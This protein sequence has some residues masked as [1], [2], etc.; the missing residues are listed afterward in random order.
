MRLMFLGALLCALTLFA[1]AHVRAQAQADL[2]RVAGIPVDATA[3]SAVAAREQALLAGQREGLRRLLARLTLPEDA[4]RLPSLDGLSIEP[5]VESFQIADERLSPTRYLATLSV[6]YVP[7]QVRALL[8]DSGTPHLDRR[9]EPVLVLP[10]LDTGQGLD[11]WGD[12]NPW[13]AAWN[14]G[15]ASPLAEIRLPLGDAGDATTVTPETL[16]DTASLQ[17]L[18]GRYG[19]VATLLA[20]ARIPEPAATPA[21]VEIEVRSGERPGEPLLRDTLTAAADEDEPALLARAVARAVEGV[22]L[23]VK[24]RLIVREEDLTELRASV[25]LADLASWVQIKDA[26]GTLTEVRNLRVE[27]FARSGAVVTIAYAGGLD[28]L[29]GAMQRVGLVLAEENGQWHLRQAGG[30]GGYQPPSPVL[31]AMP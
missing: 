28:A 11:L 23:G 7:T 18:A 4:A 31:P 1:P 27:S 10:V 29:A 5:F 25:P 14:E 24:R 21:T 19:A 15:A 9:A 8:R 3:A 12:P 6:A 2:F 30:L 20:Q 22:E 17:A 26:L 16:N 13:R